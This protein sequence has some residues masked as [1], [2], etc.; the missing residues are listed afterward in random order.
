VKKDTRSCPFCSAVEIVPFGQFI[1][2]NIKFSM[3]FC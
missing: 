2:S 1:K 3:T